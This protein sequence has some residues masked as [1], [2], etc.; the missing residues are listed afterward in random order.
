MA[1]ISSSC[2]YTVKRLKGYKF[3]NPTNI[4]KLDIEILNPYLNN[5]NL[6]NI[7]YS[8]TLELET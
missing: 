3:I 2:N 4:D 5:I 1:S 6:S 7:N 8:F